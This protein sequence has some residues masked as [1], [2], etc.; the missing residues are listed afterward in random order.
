MIDFDDIWHI[1]RVVQLFHRPVSHEDVVD[2]RWGCCDEVYVKLA[3]QPL[4][5]DLQMK[6]AEKATAKPKTECGGGFH[7]IFKAGV[8]KAELAHRVTQIFKF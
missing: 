3:F 8:I 2:H 4:A 6:E 5:D 7:F 1:G